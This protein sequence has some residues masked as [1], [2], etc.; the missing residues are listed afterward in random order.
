M[1]REAGKTRAITPDRILENVRIDIVTRKLRA[2][3][4]IVESEMAERFGASRG[5]VRIALQTL[6]NEGLI[7]VLP[8]GR[9]EVAG[10][11]FKDA[12]DMYELRW[13]IENRAIEIALENR[14]T[15]FLPLITV[16][17][18]IEKMNTKEQE[19]ADWFAIDIDFHRALVQTADNSPL[20]KAWEINS[21]IMYALMQLNTTKGYRE[22]YVREFFEKHKRIFELLITDNPDCFPVL[23]T[24]IMDARAISR[25]VLTKYDG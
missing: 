12:T 14:T 21:P 7:R 10:F 11:T 25:D 15:Y 8:N 1:E 9:K 19:Q 3:D 24:H 2:G 18:R 16:L 4:K 23:K 22:N 13:M 17:R 6:A 5:S 20:L